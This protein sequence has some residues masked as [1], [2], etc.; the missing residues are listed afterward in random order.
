MCFILKFRANVDLNN[1]V[2]I[3]AELVLKL[4]SI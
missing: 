2:R 3:L 1:L 4:L